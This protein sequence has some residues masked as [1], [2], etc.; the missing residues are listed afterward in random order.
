MLNR[1]GNGSRRFAKTGGFSHSGNH[2][3][4]LAHQRARDKSI[5]TARQLTPHCGAMHDPLLLYMWAVDRAKM[6][7]GAIIP[8]CN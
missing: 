7:R 8:D 4:Q 6:A 1:Y 5:R 2:V 3:E